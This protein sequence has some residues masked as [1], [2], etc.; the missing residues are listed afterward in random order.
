MTRK[1]RT[2]E[3]RRRR[4]PLGTL[5]KQ[6]S[7]DTKT[8]QLIEKESLVPRWINDEDNGLRIHN[9]IEGGY[10]F[11]SSNGEVIVGDSTKKED[12]NRRIKKQ[13][14]THKDG[15]SKYA[16]LMGIKREFYEEDQQKK[17]EIN[18]MVDDAIMGK[19]ETQLNKHGVA[20]DRGGT[21]VKNIKYEP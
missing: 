4:Q 15:S 20:P 8:M 7:L 10:D 14:G 18:R 3:E 5:R 12:L 9:A 21:Y 16:Y 6:M 11:I 19:D 17:E 1:E 13:V 2:A